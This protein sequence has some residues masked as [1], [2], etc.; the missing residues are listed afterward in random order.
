MDTLGEYCSVCLIQDV[1]LIQV[2]I[3]NVIWGVKCH[4]N[5]Q[6]K[7]L[8]YSPR[9]YDHNTFAL[10]SLSKWT[11]WSLTINIDCNSN[12]KKSDEWNKL[13]YIQTKRNR[14]PYCT[15]KLIKS[16]FLC[17]NRK[18]CGWQ[19]EAIFCI[20]SVWHVGWWN[21]ITIFYLIQVGNNRNDHFRYF[22][23]VHV[24]A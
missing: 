15:V 1:R 17:K 9:D 12:L 13:Y 18:I 20:S 5:E 2:S 22:L 8:E 4:S 23:G 14:K 7:R 6:W 24:S 21:L 3:D 10:I 16:R 11:N 19:F